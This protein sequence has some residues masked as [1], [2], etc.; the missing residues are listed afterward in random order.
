MR[1]G[2]KVEGKPSMVGGFSVWAFGCGNA[3]LHREGIYA[4]NRWSVVSDEKSAK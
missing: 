2:L 4:T 3:V 1:R